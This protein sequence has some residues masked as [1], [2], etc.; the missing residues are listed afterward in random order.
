MNDLAS[1][2]AGGFPEEFPSAELAAI[3]RETQAIGRYVFDHL[4]EKRPN[5]LDRRWWDE[6]IMSWAMQDEAV[7]VQL[8]R[9]VDVLPMLGDDNQLI[10][11]LN[12]Y[13]AEVRDRLPYSIR[14]AL[15]VARRAAFT[16]AAVARAARLSVMDFARRFMA[17]SNAQEVLAAA[18]RERKLRRAFT[19]D[20]LGE[21]VISQREA[22]SHFRAYCD[23]IHNVAPTVNN[24]E[25]I[26][27]IDRDH[28]DPLPRMNLSIKLSALDSQFDAIDQEGTLRRCGDRLQE[29]LRV[30]R[31]EGA[32]INVDM[33]SYEK[34]DLT[35]RIF[36]HVLD[37]PEFRDF[38]DAGIVIQCYLLDAA[39][40]L[41]ELRDWAMRRGA[42]VWVRLV[43]GAYWDYETIHHRYHGWPVPVFQQKWMSDANFEA[44]VRFV[45]RNQEHLRPAM[46]S[47]NIRSLAHGLAVAKHLGLPPNAFE[48]Q[49]LYGMADSEKR[50][51]VEMGHRLRI[52]MPYGEL[53]PGMAYLVRRLLENTSNDSFLRA[54]FVENISPDELLRNPAENERGVRSVERGTEEARSANSALPVPRSAL[55]EAPPHPSIVMNLSPT[56][57]EPITFSNY[58]PADFT[59]RRTRQEMFEALASVREKLGVYRPLFLDGEEVDAAER[60]TSRD[61]SHKDRIVGQTAAA[62]RSHV[63]QAVAAAQRAFPY[64][65]D[66]GT[67]RRAKYLQ[68]AAHLMQARFFELA[69]WEVYECAKGW[70]EATGD[71]A[72]AIDF[73]NY[74]AACALALER[75]QEVNTPGEENR[76]EYRPRGVA[77]VIAPWN[78]PLAILTGMTVAALV[79]GNTVIMKPA[80]QSP[81]IAARLMDLFRELDLPPGVLQYLPGRGETAGATLVEHPDVSLISFTGSRKVGLA[82]NVKAAEVSAGRNMTLVKKVIAEMGGKNAIIVDNDADLDEAVL[83]VMRSA[84]GYQGQKCS[85]CSRAV[86]LEGV[87]DAFLH[88]LVEAARSLKVGPAEEPDTSV[89]AVID[90]EA[91]NR[92]RQ[93]IEIGR[94]EGREVLAVDV[95]EMANEGYYIGPHI[96]ADVPPHSQIAQEEIFGPVLAVM[97]AGN[98]KEAFSIFNDSLYALTGGIYSRSPANLDRAMRELHAGN[99][100]LNRNITGALVGR[101]PFGGYKMSGI[102]AKA[103]GPDY[104]LQYVIPRTITENTMRRGFAPMEET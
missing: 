86:V 39:R 65:R 49:M 95:G 79:T 91:F 23:L 15:G 1:Q 54:G 22:E 89:S 24:W 72:E 64:W 84:F 19:L 68:D 99:L 34:K 70:R 77:A 102:G 5:L 45:M 13:L 43:K 53:I 71:V 101:Q 11:H 78:F 20:I 69:A 44:A 2:S 46:G 27:Q 18:E 94:K 82:I 35:L 58:P 30:A 59:R 67:Q 66:L 104:L 21:A 60:L 51:L 97:K 75:A 12:E 8:F 83:G 87:Y 50:A 31:R 63:E 62:D 28:R 61:P 14:V 7:K 36:Q 73:C 74:Y 56:P 90:E 16:R 3:E 29:L 26:P 10:H 48:V 55:D 38:A 41:R 33:E 9:F 98:L 96:F 40:D 52:Y 76:F 100:Y 42:P 80:E 81:I 32:F 17:G 92:I 57:D 6:R 4:E 85:A 103:G 37:E 25:E 47:H 93:F 88:R